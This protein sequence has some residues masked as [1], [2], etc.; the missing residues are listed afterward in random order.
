MPF[1]RHCVLVCKMVA[2]IAESLT[3]GRLKKKK[4]SKCYYLVTS[5]RSQSLQGLGPEQNPRPAWLRGQRLPHQ[6]A[7]PGAQH[8]TLATG[9]ACGV[10]MNL[11]HSTHN[12]SP[13]RFSLKVESDSE[14]VNE[15]SKVIQILLFP[16]ENITKEGF[17][18]LGALLRPT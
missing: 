8:S 3:H 9:D 7:L 15:E 16:K 10:N 13:K 1:L 4:K 6:S 14:T 2:I 18:Y 12:Q 11:T 5:E 17:H